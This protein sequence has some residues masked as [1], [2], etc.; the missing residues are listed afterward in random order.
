[1]K[2]YNEKKFSGDGDRFLEKCTMKLRLSVRLRG[3]L[4]GKLW[5]REMLLVSKAIK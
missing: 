3:R 2:I 1:M 4:F 5:Q